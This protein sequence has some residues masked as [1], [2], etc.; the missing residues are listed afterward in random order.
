MSLPVLPAFAP[1]LLAFDLD[2]T[3][4]QDGGTSVPEVT[5][6]ALHRLK[7]LGVRVALVTGLAHPERLARRRDAGSGEQLDRAPAHR[8]ARGHGGH[9]HLVRTALC[10]KVADV[11]GGLLLVPQ[12]TLAADT[13]SGTRPSFSPAAAPADLADTG[14]AAGTYGGF[15]TIRS[16]RPAIPWYQSAGTK[17]AVTPIIVLN[18]ESATVELS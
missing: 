5:A 1:Q 13:K 12:F 4:I 16:K 9:H 14:D 6:A 10:R 7:S 3:L 11:G 17:S 15:E 2:G 18:N 8:Q